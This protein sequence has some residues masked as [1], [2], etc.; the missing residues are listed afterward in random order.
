MKNKLH[1]PTTSQLR[2]RDKI[3]MPTVEILSLKIM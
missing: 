2:R 3:C 1:M